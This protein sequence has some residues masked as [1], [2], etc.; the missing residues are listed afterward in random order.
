M[1]ESGA[2]L[3]FI[4]G[5]YIL[6]RLNKNHFWFVYLEVR[7]KIWKV[8]RSWYLIEVTHAVRSLRGYRAG[9]GDVVVVSNLQKTC[10]RH[11]TTTPPTRIKA[12][13]SAGNTRIN[14]PLF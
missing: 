7:K 3:V 9:S 13:T 6:L 5:I 1:G 10:F 4:F 8:G 11:C 2:E 14:F 12:T